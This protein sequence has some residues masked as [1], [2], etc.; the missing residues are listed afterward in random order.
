MISKRTKMRKNHF[1]NPTLSADF[2]R[3]NNPRKPR[4]ILR[5]ASTKTK[6]LSACGE[7]KLNYR[8]RL[9]RIKY[10]PSETIGA[11]LVQH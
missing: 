11:T 2:L 6:I 7:V 1:K 3:L 9:E 8:N 4:T 10:S 5:A